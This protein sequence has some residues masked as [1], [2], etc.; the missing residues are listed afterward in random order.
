MVS[1]VPEGEQSHG[2]ARLEI[3]EV[4]QQRIQKAAREGEAL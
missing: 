2:A 4:L 3:L 1:A